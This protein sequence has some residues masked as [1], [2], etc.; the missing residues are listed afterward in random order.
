MSETIRCGVIGYGGAFNMGRAHGTYIQA[1]PGLELTAICDI[2]PERTAAAAVDFPD[3]IT[4]NAVDELLNSDTIDLAVI[5]LPHNL[6]AEISIQASKAGKHVV[7]EK[8]MC[9]TVDEATAMIEAARAANKMLT[10]FHNRRQDGDYRTLRRLVVDENIIGEVF[11]VEVFSGGYGAQNPLWWRSSKKI[12]GGYFYDWGAHFLDWLLGIVPGQITD[13]SGYFQK[14]LW[15]DVTNEDQVQAVIRFESGTVANV[16][17]SSIAY[18]GKPKWWILGEKGAIVDRGGYFEVTGPFQANGH[19]A[20]LKVPYDGNSEWQT[21]YTNVSDHLL[22]G[23][24][25]GVKPEQARRIIAVLEGAE[26]ASLAGHSLPVPTD[27]ED[28]AFVRTF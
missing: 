19:T 10:V 22:K 5:V 13:I 18:A 11:S 24:E 26:K 17:M 15:H 27:A 28:A 21:F 8:P 23:A 2:S 20:I 9:V 4:F 3:I 1:T 16:T 6:H 7:V 14:R 25:L 12:S